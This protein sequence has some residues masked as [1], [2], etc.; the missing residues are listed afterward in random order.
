MAPQTEQSS[1]SK[2]D[3]KYF[4]HSLLP[5]RIHFP[6]QVKK[7]E[8]QLFLAVL[9]A[10]MVNAQRAV[11]YFIIMGCI[12]MGITRQYILLSSLHRYKKILK[13]KHETRRLFQDLYSLWLFY[14]QINNRDIADI[15]SE[16]KK[17]INRLNEDIRLDALS[18]IT[19]N[20]MI[21]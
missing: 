7:K 1:Q 6:R 4:K 3:L 5:L 20:L 19:L 10:K 13:R 18:L 15:K 21:Y 8:Y 16:E 9:I 11:P 14:Q 2:L 17:L 12:S